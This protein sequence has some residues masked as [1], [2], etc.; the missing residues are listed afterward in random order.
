MSTVATSQ[1]L[2]YGT[3]PSGRSVALLA[4]KNARAVVLLFIASDCPISNRYL[5]EM[6]RLKQKFLPRGV[7]FWF[8]YPNLTETSS[9][10]RTHQAAYMG[11]DGVRLLTDPRQQL[12]HLTGVKVTPE[13]ALLVPDGAGLRTVYAGRID[14][15]YLSIGSQRPQARRHDLEDAIE[16]A[17]AGSPI[18]PPGGPA[19]G[20]GI[21][22]TK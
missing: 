7:T 9:T 15:R 4:P 17:L 5:P 2:R 16:A 19:V 6:R 10:I 13:A 22:S 8:V 20:C 21:V 14:D 3:D 11:G 1:V 12:A 18:Q